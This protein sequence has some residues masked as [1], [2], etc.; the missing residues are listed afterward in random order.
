[1]SDIYDWHRWF[2]WR[3]VWLNDGYWAFL[4]PVLRMHTMP[5]NG[6]DCISPY[7]CDIKGYWV[8]KEAA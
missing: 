4:R 7:A 1:M 6:V 3:P 2:A 8:Y 5:A